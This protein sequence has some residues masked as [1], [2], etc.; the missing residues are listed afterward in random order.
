MNEELEG[1]GP[2]LERIKDT[3]VVVALT[4][5]LRLST[6]V[7]ENFRNQERALTKKAEEQTLDKHEKKVLED[8][9]KSIAAQEDIQSKLQVLFLDFLF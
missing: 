9:R 5:N 1:K 4:D 2:L 8:L 6:T 7:L 3:P